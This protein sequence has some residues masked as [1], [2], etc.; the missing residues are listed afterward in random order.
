V[1]YKPPPLEAGNH[2]I[3]CMYKK[4]KIKIIEEIRDTACGV[5]KCARK[6]RAYVLTKN[7]TCKIIGY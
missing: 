6:K 5:N 4:T 7:R 1:T 3:K 2:K